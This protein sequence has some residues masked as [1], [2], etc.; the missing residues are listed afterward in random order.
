M[1][2]KRILLRITQHAKVYLLL[3]SNCVLFAQFFA[4][5]QV[6]PRSSRPPTMTMSLTSD[7]KNVLKPHLTSG[8]IF[9]LRK[10]QPQ[11]PNKTVQAPSDRNRWHPREQM[12]ETLGRAQHSIPW[13]ARSTNMSHKKSIHH[14]A[15]HCEAII[16]T[17]TLNHAPQ[18]EKK[19]KNTRGRI[20]RKSRSGRQP[21]PPLAAPCV[22]ENFEN[23]FLSPTCSR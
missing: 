6:F 22:G 8:N 5:R 9:D 16:R 18:N 10:K 14:C 12:Q 17:L 2:R 23:K 13:C 4:L 19:K 3:Q 7:L 11:T 15:E 1:R 21:M 20:R